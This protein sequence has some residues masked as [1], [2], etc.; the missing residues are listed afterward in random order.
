M[1]AAAVVRVAVETPQHSGLAQPL[2]YLAEHPLPAGTL[3]RVPLGRRDVPGIVWP[4]PPA[5]RRAGDDA[6][7]AAGLKPV[8][9]GARRAAAAAGASG[10]R[11]SSSPPRYYQRGV[12]ELALAVLPPEL[13]KLD[14]AQLRAGASSGCSRSAAP[15]AAAAAGGVGATAPARR[16]S[17]APS[18]RPR[19][20]RLARSTR[21]AP[22]STV[23]LHG[24][25]GSG[26]TE[27]YLRAAERGAGGAAGRCWCWCPR[28]T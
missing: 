11:W 6:P 15:A 27:V 22:G 8:A 9:R 24:V 21:D 26:K 20:A 2:D 5:T 23:L 25:T 16:P 4:E 12:G 7:P 28:S 3:V 14:D 19:S 13:R 10:A 18:R 17:R 1:S